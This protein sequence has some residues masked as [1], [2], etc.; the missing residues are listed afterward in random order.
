MKFLD[1]DP[2]SKI[3]R[4]MA[5]DREAGKNVINSVMDVEPFIDWNK[6]AAE[7]LDKRGDWWFVGTIPP[8][9]VELWANECGAKPFTREWQNYA[10]KQLN[11]PDYRKL[12]P[13]NIRLKTN[14]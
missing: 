10:A 6:A 13:N 9:I 3:T 11:L 4:H 5:T 7:K 8:I 14:G 2:L 12:N 1:Y